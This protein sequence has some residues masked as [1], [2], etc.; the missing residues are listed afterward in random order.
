MS[1]R[2]QSLLGKLLRR[3]QVWSEMDDEMRQHVELEAEELV[4]QGVPP[5]EALQRA[6]LKSGSTINQRY[7][8]HSTWP[9][10]Q[11]WV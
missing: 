10:G 5:P 9:S 2:G 1:H 7:R 4:R 3:R 11:R 8:T 6:R